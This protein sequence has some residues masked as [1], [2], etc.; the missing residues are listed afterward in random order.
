VNDGCS[1]GA[2]NTVNESDNCCYMDAERHF[3]DHVSRNLTLQGKIQ[4]V[5]LWIGKRLK[6]KEGARK[7]EIS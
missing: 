6:G 4:S 5:N 1:D 2:E 3:Q 7:L